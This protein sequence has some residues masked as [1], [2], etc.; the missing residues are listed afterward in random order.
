MSALR[1]QVV[2]F[3]VVGVVATLSDALVYGGLLWT[4]T[5]TSEDVAKALSF[6]V[7]T[8]VAFVLNKLWT[9]ED[10]SRDPRQ[11]AAFFALY[12]TSWGINVGMNRLALWGAMSLDLPF[13]HALAFCIATGAS[14]VVNF[15]GQRFW[16]F[17]HAAAGPPA[18]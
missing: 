18:T 1:R 4:G 17:R 14:M 9:F 10:R 7:G 8:C 16:V 13:A 6:L 12:G 15:L 2:R 3:A 11:V 5:V